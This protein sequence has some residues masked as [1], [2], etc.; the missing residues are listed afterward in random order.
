MRS[1]FIGLGSEVP[2]VLLLFLLYNRLLVVLQSLMHLLCLLSLFLLLLLSLAVPEVKGHLHSLQQGVD[3][4][5][6]Q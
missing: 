6:G 5:G 1:F 4:I 3:L 2:N